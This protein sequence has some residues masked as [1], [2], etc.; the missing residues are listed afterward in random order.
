M[1]ETFFTFLNQDETIKVVV[2]VGSFTLFFVG[3][4]GLLTQ[5]HIIKIFMSIAIM[6]TAVFLFFIG[7]SFNKNFTAPILGDG[8]TTF[9]AMNDPVPQAMILTAIVIG[10]AVLALGVSFAIEYY[11]LTKRNSIDEMREMRN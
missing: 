5:K 11:K 6:E 3:L 8:L 7:S 2:D 1:I 9:T 10:M 4:F